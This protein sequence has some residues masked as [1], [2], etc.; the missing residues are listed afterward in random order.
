M[1]VFVIAPFTSSRR[2]RSCVLGD[3]EAGNLLDNHRKWHATWWPGS[4]SRRAGTS[5]LH[6]GTIYGQRV[7]KR[8]PGGGLSGLGTSPCTTSLVRLMAGSG[9]GTAA[10][11][12]SV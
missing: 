8:Q 3:E 1:A 4:I 6:R 5:S 7:W 12:A 10:S 11:S 9:T 2:G